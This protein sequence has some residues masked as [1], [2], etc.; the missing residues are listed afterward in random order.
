MLC[1]LPLSTYADIEL[2]D[3]QN[4]TLPCYDTDKLFEKLTK[5]YQE[6]PLLMGET[7]DIA[8]ST[9]SLW[10][11]KQGESWTIITSKDKISCLVGVGKKIKLL[12]YGKS[13]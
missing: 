2:I 4:I 11:S 1:F 12:R 13:V 7:D 5:D 6:F 9:M 8:Q 3:R 10:I